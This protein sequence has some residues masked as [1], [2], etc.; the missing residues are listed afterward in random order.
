MLLALEAMI[1]FPP[2]IFFDSTGYAFTFIVAYFFGCRVGAYI[3]YPTISTDMLALVWE[4]RPTYNNSGAVARSTLARWVWV[5]GVCVCVWLCLHHLASHL[6]LSR[7]LSYVKVLYYN[8]F[9]IAY[10]IAGRFADVAIVN[11][12]WTYEHIVRLWKVM[13]CICLPSGFVFA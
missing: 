4:R 1:R 8:M 6:P 11:S 3:H 2:D 5:W 7:L 12:S 13:L 9:A 10:G